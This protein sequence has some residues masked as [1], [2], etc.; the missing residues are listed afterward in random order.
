MTANDST[1]PIAWG[2]A[3]HG[4]RLYF[5][6]AG[7]GLALFLTGVEATIVST[8][9]VTITNDLQNS[10]Q[11]SWVITSY[12]LT[13]TGFLIIWSNCSKI[14]GVKATLLTSL[15]LF[16]AFS[17][18][19]AG[20]E[21]LNQL[22]ICRAFQGLGGAGVYTLTLFS[23]VRIVPYNQYD[24]ASSLGGGILS[25][26]LVLGPLL[27]GAIAS[28]GRWSWVFLYN[29]PAGAFAWLLILY[30]IPAHFPRSSPVPTNES[31]SKQIWLNIMSSFRGVDILGAFLILT[32]CSFTIAALQE[33]NFAY[34][35]TSGLVLSFLVISGVSWVAFLWWEWFVCR[36]GLKISQLFPWRLT[37]NRVFMG[38]ALGFFTT[39]LALT[40]CV[41][42][43]PQR[44][45]IVYGSSPIGAG[46]KLLSFSLSCPLGVITCSVLAGRLK[47]PF[48]YIALVGTA[49]QATG[50][51][52][53]SEIASKTELWPGQFGYLV[54]AGL[55][56]GLAMSAFYMAAPLVVDEEDQSTALGIGIQLRML[57]GVLGVAASTTILYHFLESR[58]SSNLRPWELRALLK[59]TEALAGFPPEI[60]LR[61][62]VV[63]AIAYNMQVKLSA[64]FSVGQLLA[65]AMI[66]KRQNVRYLKGSLSN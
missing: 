35:W 21:S 62:R 12:L 64:A 45:Q 1:L 59:T 22:I 24:K 58:L 27:G 3:L 20:A 14:F 10:G 44:C 34:P 30:A 46:V 56:V 13:Y 39:G 37:R 50:L 49:F 63:Y 52:L 33:G 54:L 53:F 23:F 65:V 38:I 19:C 47:L 29:V 55:G 16:V 40:V 18:G 41:I 15:L 28:T 32:A 60:Q 26:G 43:I 25:L 17:G 4:L 57:G 42:N 31:T 5:G 51:F 7:L 8:S 2:G 9:L 36:R 6:I 48:C 11:S 66:W 61:V